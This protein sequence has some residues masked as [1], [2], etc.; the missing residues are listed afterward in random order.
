MI[1]ALCHPTMTPLLFELHFTL[2]H[3]KLNSEEEWDRSLA[4][5]GWARVLNAMTW[6]ELLR[7]HI[8]RSMPRLKPI[9]RKDQSVVK[10]GGFLTCMYVCMYV[11]CGQ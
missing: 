10:Q 11:C 1:R 2:L 7:R 5:G 9:K 8:V 4:L 3:L 6:E